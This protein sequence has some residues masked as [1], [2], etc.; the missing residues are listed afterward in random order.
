MKT[1]WNKRVLFAF[2]FMKI[3]KKNII[4]AFVTLCISVTIQAQ[5]EGITLVKDGKLKVNTVFNPADSIKTDTVKT[6]TAK[7]L[8]KLEVAKRNV[9]YNIL[10]GPSYTPDLGV[11][12]GG[13]SLVTFRVNPSDTLQ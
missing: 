2:V 11:L 3:M 9:H 10:G 5:D 7:E 4:I 12:I 13:S 8:R 1:I 6:L